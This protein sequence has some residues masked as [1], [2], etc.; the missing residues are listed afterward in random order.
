MFIVLKIP[1]AIRLIRENEDITIL[2]G[3]KDSSIVVMNKKDYNRKIDDLINEGIQQGNY[4]KLMI[5]S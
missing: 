5:I 4:K 2:S 1:C 3:D